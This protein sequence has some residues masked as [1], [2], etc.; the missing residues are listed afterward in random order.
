MKTCFKTHLRNCISIL[1]LG[2]LLLGLPPQA[3][4]QNLT[5]LNQSP[6]KFAMQ[7]DAKES[8]EQ[9]A[10]PGY[11]VDKWLPAQVPG[12]AF[13]SYVAAGLEKEPSYGDNAYTVDQQKYCD[14]SGQRPDS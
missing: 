9:I 5:S 11:A 2:F 14:Y 1:G 4:G 3:Q 8:G 6:W 12:T 13:G 7:P 10:T